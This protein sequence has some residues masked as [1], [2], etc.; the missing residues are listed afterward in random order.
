MDD[1]RL[2]VREMVKELI[3][4]DALFK[5]GE[6]P[7]ILNKF[8][9]PGD[10]HSSKDSHNKRSYMAKPQLYSI[11]KNAVDIYNMLEDNQ[12]ISDWME[13]HISQAEQMIDAVH[14]KLDYKNSPAY[15]DKTL[16]PVVSFDD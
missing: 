4:D 5:N 16:G 11:V 9:T 10:S 12:E 8:D 3:Q 15:Y 2:L 14:G 7:G 13:S 6:H 1:L